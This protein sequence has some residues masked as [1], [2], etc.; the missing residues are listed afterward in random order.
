MVFFGY[1]FSSPTGL[2]ESYGFIHVDLFYGDVN[3]S[4]LEI[5]ADSGAMTTIFLS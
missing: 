3:T 1:P 5:I 2:I 4:L